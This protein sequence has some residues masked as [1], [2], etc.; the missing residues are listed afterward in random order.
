MK[1]LDSRSRCIGNPA[2]LSPVSCFKLA[3]ATLCLVSPV[4]PGRAAPPPTITKIYDAPGQ[5][6]GGLAGDGS[7][8][9]LTTLA[10][11]SGWTFSQVVS[12]SASGS[13]RWS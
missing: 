13:F 2:R 8:L 4:L 10:K 5:I 6:W 1:P 7:N 3:V 9:Y 12:I 11:N